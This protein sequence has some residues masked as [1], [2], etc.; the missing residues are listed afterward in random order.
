MID[1]TDRDPTPDPVLESALRD[2]S[3]EPPMEAVDWDRL[4]GTIATRARERFRVRDRKAVWWQPMAAWA[5][6]A[7]PLGL[8]AAIALFLVL[9]SVAGSDENLTGV[10]ESADAVG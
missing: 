7:I 3:P 9:R 10:L 8:A 5:R 6:P 2:L 4:A 1:E